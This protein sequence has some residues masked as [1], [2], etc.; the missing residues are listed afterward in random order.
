M[1]YRIF[2]KFYRMAGQRMAFECKDFL[3]EGSKILDLGCGSGITGRCFKDFFKADI[4]GV[5]IKDQ[6]VEKIPFQIFNG[7]K[8]PFPENFFDTT[9]ISFVLH[10]SQEPLLLLKEAKRVTKDKIIIYEDLTEGFLATI[11]SKIHCLTFDHFFQKQKS[12][13]KFQNGQNW[14]K[15]FEELGLILAFEKRVNSSLNPV[16]KRVFILEKN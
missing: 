10:H 12:G 11:F 3:S 13:E 9:L 4:L 16:E 7:D 5:D 8:I 6:R 15:I 2:Q 1:Y 14:K